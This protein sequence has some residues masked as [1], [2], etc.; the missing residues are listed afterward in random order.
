MKKKNK[1]K[2]SKRGMKAQ[3]KS[4]HCSSAINRRISKIKSMT[5]FIDSTVSFGKSAIKA[6]AWLKAVYEIAKPYVKAMMEWFGWSA[7]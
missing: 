1:K 3:Q 6:F 5:K 4:L 7:L 2:P